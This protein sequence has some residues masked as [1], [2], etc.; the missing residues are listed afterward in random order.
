MAGFNLGYLITYNYLWLYGFDLGFFLHGNGAYQLPLV[1]SV[2]LIGLKLCG[3][4][5]KAYPVVS[6]SEL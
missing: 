4:S 1:I 5:P 6:A 3:S 2:C